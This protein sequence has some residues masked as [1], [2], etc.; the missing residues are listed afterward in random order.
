VFHVHWLLTSGIDVS[1]RF[2]PGPDAL[3]KY[4]LDWAKFVLADLSHHWEDEVI[5]F[6][7]STYVSA[8]Q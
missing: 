6:L 4:F 8:L 2:E 3:G 1:G 5:T 7:V